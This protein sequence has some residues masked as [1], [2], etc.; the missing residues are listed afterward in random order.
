MMTYRSIDLRPFGQEVRRLRK[1][2]GLTLDQLAAMSGVARLTLMNL[3]LGRSGTRYDLLL[4]I[5]DALDCR[6][7]LEP[8]P[9]PEDLEDGCN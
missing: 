2:R 4:S 7:T 8:Y 6:L 3:E 9:T 5:A 1:M